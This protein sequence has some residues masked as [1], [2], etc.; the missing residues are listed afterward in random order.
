MSGK[1]KTPDPWMKFYPQDWRADEKLRLC[2]LAARGLWI[3]MLSI[4][5]R[6]ERYGQLLIA[7]ATPTDAQ[8]AVQAGASPEEVSALLVELENAGVFS[9]AAKG[10]IYSRRMT[11]DKKRSETNTKNGKNGGNPKLG[12]KTIN[13][14]SVKQNETDPDKPQKP[15]ARSQIEEEDKSSPSGGGAREKPDEGRYAFAGKTVRL[16]AADLDR[17]RKTYHAIP[18]IMAELEAIDAWFQNPELAES[19]RK[20]WFTA[21]PGMLSKKHSEALERQKSGQPTFGFAPRRGEAQPDFALIVGRR[22]PTP[23]GPPQ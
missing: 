22:T 20:N 12:N 1:Q 14:G 6:S 10:V 5:H 15:E 13:S 9:R 21:V 8:L 16:N 4:M 11:R 23:Q 3:E 19:K 18:D 17:W 7:G 2:S